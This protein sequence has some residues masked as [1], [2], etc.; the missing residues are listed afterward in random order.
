MLLLR[1]LNNLPELQ[2]EIVIR[3]EC[4]RMT[5]GEIAKS[6]GVPQAV[7]ESNL[8]EG[9]GALLRHSIDGASS[10]APSKR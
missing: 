2:R 9:R 10:S 6:L 4:K 3:R 7:V 8:R 5:Y 1:L